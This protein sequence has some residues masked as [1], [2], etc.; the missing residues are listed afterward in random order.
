MIY[1]VRADENDI[2][3]WQEKRY[4]LLNPTVEIE[5]NAAGSFDFS[6]PPSHAFYDDIKPFV[7]TIEIYE[8]EEQIWF[9]RVLEI[10]TGFLKN[11]QVH[12]EGALAFFNDTIQRPHE[13]T[14]IWLHD[15][16]R[17]VIS[18]HNA[19]VENN[20]Q[21][22]VGTI[23]VPNIQVYRNL[24]YESTL[25]V[26]KRQCLNAKGGYFFT[27]RENGVN[28]IDW[29][30]EMP[31]E[32]NQPIEFGLN[33]LDLSSTFSGDSF[34]T[35][36][37]PLGE[38]DLTV[39]EVNGGSDVIVSEAAATYGR[40]TKVA[41]FP[42]VRYP[43]TLYEDGLE[44]MQEH[45]F[46]DLVI[47]C[48]AADLHWQN[49]NYELFRVGQRIR[50]LSNPHLIDKYFSLSKISISLDT[51]QKTIQ[52]GTAKK[53]ALTEILNNNESELDV[54]AIN[55]LL[56]PIK[57]D[58]EDIYGDPTLDE[59]RERLREQGGNIED[60][61]DAVGID[62]PF[63]MDDF[64]IEDMDDVGTWAHGFDDAITQYRD[65]L[66][67]QTGYNDVRTEMNSIITDL[68]NVDS[69]LFDLGS[70]LSGMD[71]RVTTLEN[72]TDFGQ[73]TVQVNGVAQATGTINF[74]T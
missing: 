50:C 52:L 2:L 18:N 28:Y 17:T 3:N 24:R 54:D 8:N 16:F 21:F 61:F 53:E 69:S 56:Q 37:V 9:G 13:Y 35:C 10:T 57:D 71:T 14:T 6:L 40:I 48:S 62:C 38:N 25:D 59:W 70:G 66:S 46:D 23:T 51:A 44:Y 41:K 32:C 73:W 68:G 7:T 33:L 12:C 36:V 58:I 4:T 20:R 29:L 30:A 65:T 26:L 45:Q 1:R 64:I 19:Q 15:F 39:A 22:T 67:E 49:D 43:D 5:L 74:V 63:D 60:L 42:S 27:R 47:N 72:S 55:G 31:Y 34:C 11:K